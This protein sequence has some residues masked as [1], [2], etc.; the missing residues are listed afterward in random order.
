MDN[1]SESNANTVSNDSPY[2]RI[3]TSAPWE[4][5]NKKYDSIA[6]TEPIESAK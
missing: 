4:R 3:Y 1:N 6:T 5:Q 2:K